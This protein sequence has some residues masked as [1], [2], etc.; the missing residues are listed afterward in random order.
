MIAK[1]HFKK[2]K[3]KT[4]EEK[5]TSKRVLR[6]PT[7]KFHKKENKKTNYEPYSFKKKS[8]GSFKKKTYQ[9]SA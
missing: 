6:K 8:D 2:I 3:Q 5:P 9:K 1:P 7:E 4:E